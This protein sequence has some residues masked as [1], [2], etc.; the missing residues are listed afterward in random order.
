M[1]LF[2]FDLDGTLVNSLEIIGNTFN[3]V[4]VQYGLPSI[5][6]DKFNYFVGDGPVVLT[7]RA[8]AYLKERGRIQEGEEEYI[9]QGLY[10]DYVESYDMIKDDITAAYE[11]IDVVLSELHKKGRMIA[12]CTNKRRK[13]AEKLVADIFNIKFDYI[14]ALEDGIRRK[15]EP[16]MVVR[17]L[18]ALDISQ[19]EALYF[20]DTNT[21]M[22]TGQNAE[23]DTVGVTWGFRERDELED[24]KPMAVIDRPEEILKFL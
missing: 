19:E 5:S 6:L 21:D 4:L 24:L 8:I 9:Y 14:S 20:G 2:I 16:D 13:A 7:R 17:I 10:H 3:A 22:L 15:P 1:K 11:G 23:V 18:K 12:I